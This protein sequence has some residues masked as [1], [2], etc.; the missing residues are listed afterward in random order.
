MEFLIA[1]PEFGYN[2]LISFVYCSCLQA[3][4]VLIKKTLCA[5]HN[6]GKLDIISVETDSNAEP[7][8]KGGVTYHYS[9]ESYE[10]RSVYYHT[11][12]NC[13]GQPYLWF[14]AF[15]LKAWLKTRR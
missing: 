8:R 6:A 12:V 15:R 11:F 13:I 7:E 1:L 14:D 2:N 3:D 9:D 4:Q 5:L 10:E